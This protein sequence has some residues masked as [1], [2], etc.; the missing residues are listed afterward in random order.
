MKKIISLLCMLTTLLAM[1][2]FLFSNVSAAEVKTYSLRNDFSETNQ[3]PVWFYQMYDLKEKKYVNLDNY[4]PTMLLWASKRTDRAWGGVGNG[5][6]LPFEFGDCAVATFES[7]ESGP[8]SITYD[9]Q[10]NPAKKSKGN[11]WLWQGGDG[12]RIKIMQN[13]K[14]IF[15]VGAEWF[16]LAPIVANTV[17]D[18]QFDIKK[19]DKIHFYVDGGV[20]MDISGDNLNWWPNININPTATTNSSSKQSSSY[21]EKTSSST[22]NNV[23]STLQTSSE[24]IISSQEISAGNLYSVFSDDNKVSSNALSNDKDNSTKSNSTIIY[25]IIGSVIVIALAGLAGYLLFFKKKNT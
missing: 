9:P 8:C 19:G 1:T 6:W 11:A 12:V 16:D 2:T 23:N 20:A 25:I 10:V 3:G 5:A 18:V 4:S 7:P 22:L 17:P 21:S 14:V 15:P 13:D 24:T